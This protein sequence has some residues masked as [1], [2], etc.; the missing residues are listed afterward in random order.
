[1]L[2]QHCTPAHASCNEETLLDDCVSKSDDLY[3]ASAIPL[4]PRTASQRC[5]GH[6][7]SAAEAGAGWPLRRGRGEDGAASPEST[8]GRAPPPLPGAGL[9]LGGH[10]PAPAAP[11]AMSAAATGGLRGGRAVRPAP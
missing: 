7:A 6:R 3:K 9:G 5:C 11:R 1:M 10:V 4:T 2:S 8:V